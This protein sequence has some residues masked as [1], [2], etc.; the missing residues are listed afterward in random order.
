[1]G[2]FFVVFAGSGFF[3]AG[4]AA[5]DLRV[6]DLLVCAFVEPVSKALAA[7]CSSQA[8]AANAASVRASRRVQAEN[9]WRRTLGGEMT[10][11]RET[12]SCDE[13]RM[14]FF[15][16]VGMAGARWSRRSAWAPSQWALETMWG[17]ERY[18]LRTGA[19]KN[20]ISQIKLTKWRELCL[21]LL[22]LNHSASFVGHRFCVSLVVA[23]FW[24]FFVCGFE[25]CVP[26]N[27]VAICFVGDEDLSDSRAVRPGPE[28]HVEAPQMVGAEKN[29]TLP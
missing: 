7:R 20:Q 14:L 8:A 24:C 27:H 22:R 15:E 17:S 4:F 18:R 11:G 29:A 5:V 26:L 23:M 3:V 21:P 13:W 25:I 1:M 16:S 19:R 6:A 12:A 10:S 28:W 9:S 2:S